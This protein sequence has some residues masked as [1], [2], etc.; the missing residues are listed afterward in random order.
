MKKN[1][2]S[3][4]CLTQKL[5]EFSR[6]SKI[7]TN[8]RFTILQQAFKLKFAP[9]FAPLINLLVQTYKN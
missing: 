6:G 4:S 5:G 1:H 7:T 2:K 3:S 8:T 9:L